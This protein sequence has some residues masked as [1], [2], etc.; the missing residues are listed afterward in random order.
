[1]NSVMNR[2]RRSW[3]SGLG[4]A[5]VTCLLGSPQPARAH[6]GL[7]VSQAILWR[8]DSMMIPTPYWGLFVGTDGGPFRW[9]CDEA[10]NTNQQRIINITSDG[11]VLFATDRMGLSVSTDGGCSW[12]ATTPPVSELDV[13]A[14]AADPS[15]T[16]QHGMYVLAN[17]YA[18]RSKTGLW[19]SDDAGQ[20]WKPVR[21][22]TS[23]LPG[24]L[25]VSP[26][27]Q[28]LAVTA[29]SETT[30]RTATL[31]LSTDGGAGFTS[32]VLNVPLDGQP[33]NTLVPI[34][35]DSEPPGQGS[36]YLSS[37]IDTGYVL[38]RYDG[39]AAPAKVLQIAS[40]I[41][42]LLREPE[43]KTLLV[44][45]AQGIYALQPDQS[46]KLL[47]AVSSALCLSSHKGQLYSCS[48]NY[49]PDFAAVARLSGVSSSK[50]KVFQYSDTV[51]PVECPAGTTVAN[52]CP[53]LWASY[54]DQLGVMRPMDPPVPPT[55]TGY[56]G[57]CQLGGQL[58]SLAGL[59]MLGT[60]LALLL[61]RRRRRLH[62]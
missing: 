3:L 27:G 18:D 11:Q 47:D 41:H 29:L 61:G 12:A 4:L 33:L 53:K 24:G 7:P 31:H 19:R 10:I 6:G 28:Y 30:P 40:T 44:A 57:G 38:L 48:W 14:M 37:V 20:T 52:I 58:P 35:F 9:I 15:P 8:G 46:F 55:Q 26:D 32:R 45:T 54:A 36:L 21:M 22:L 17:S 16:G 59:G 25:T 23:G 42:S 13:I 62:T 49:A 34:G 1:M 56:G 60:S 50:T 39:L 43:T 51:G 2:Q 5:V